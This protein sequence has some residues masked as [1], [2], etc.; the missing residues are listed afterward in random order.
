MYYILSQIGQFFGDFLR[1]YLVRG[2]EGFGFTLG[3]KCII[4]KKG[5]ISSGR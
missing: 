5:E 1:E 3:H 4:V 2:K